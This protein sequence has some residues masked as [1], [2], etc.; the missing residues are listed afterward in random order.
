MYGKGVRVISMYASCEELLSCHMTGTTR[1][2]PRLWD[3][4]KYISVWCACAVAANWQMGASW[5]SECYI[6][7]RHHRSVT[8]IHRIYAQ[9]PQTCAEYDARLLFAVEWMVTGINV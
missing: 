2:F 6:H 3:M 4:H 1:H 7:L 9:G 5:I 8:N